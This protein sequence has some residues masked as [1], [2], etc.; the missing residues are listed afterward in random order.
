MYTVQEYNNHIFYSVKLLIYSN[1]LS[2]APKQN[3]YYEFHILLD[4][5][6]CLH[7]ANR[8]LHQTIAA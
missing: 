3:L 1:M 8:F 4:A 5:Y 6:I 2:S 7:S